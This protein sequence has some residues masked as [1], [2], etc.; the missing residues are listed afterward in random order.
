MADALQ[1]QDIEREWSKH[2]IDQNRRGAR[3]TFIIVLFLYPAFG[4]LDY[5]YAPPDQLATLWGSRVVVTAVTL[6]MLFAGLNSKWFERWPMPITGAYI[7]MCGWAISLMVSIMGG[8]ASTY[9]AGLI[10]VMIGAGLLNLWSRNV[11]ITVHGGIVLSYFLPNLLAGRIGDKFTAISNFFF[12]TGS[13]IIVAAGQIFTYRSQYQQLVTQLALQRTKAHLEEAHD[14]LKQL[15]QFKSKFFANITHELKTPLTMILSPLELTIQGE[16]GPVTDV[17]KATLGSMLRSGMKLLKLINDLLDLTK[18]EESRIR[19]RIGQHDLVE[20]MRSLVAQVQPLAQRKS[21]DMTFE[22]DV[23]RSVAWCDIERVERVF[24]NLLSNAAK[25]TPQ[26]GHIWVH[27]VDAPDKVTVTVRDDGPGFPADKAKAVFERF[28]QVEMGGTRK[29]GGTGI[30]LA[31]ARELVDLHGGRIWAQAEVGKGACFTV[32]LPKDREHFRPEAVASERPASTAQEV[33]KAE[34]E[35]NF[36]EMAVAVAGRDDYKLLDIAEATDRRVVERDP[37]ENSRAWTVLVVEDN[38]DIIRVVHLTLRRHFK[39]MAAPDGQRGLEM[40]RAQKPNLIVTDLMMP[41]MDGLEMTR[42]L[43]ADPNTKHIPIIMLTARGDIEDRVTGLDSGVNAYLSKP[44]SAKELLSTT[45]GLLNIQET[46]ADILLTQRLDSLETIAGGLAHEINNPLNY[47][48]NAV[49]RVQMDMAE[50]LRL[51]HI[52]RELTAEEAAKL[53]KLE[54]RV[55]RMFDTADSGVKRIAGTVQLMGRYSREGYTRAPRQHDVFE[56]A[57]D[58]VG[59]VL[60]AT[61]REVKVTTD[62]EGQGVIE[63]IP[64]EFNQ[65]L[66]NLVQ[67][68]IEAVTEGTGTV[69]LRGRVEDG[70][71]LL[72]VKDNGPGI[73]EDVR[74]KIFTPFFTTKGPGR[75]MGMGLTITWRVVQSIGGTIQVGGQVGV[76]TEFALKLPAMASAPRS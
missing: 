10:L 46:Q 4:I 8:L 40:A 32:E 57:R 23:Q 17:Q 34:T 67:N 62:F 19:L 64:E 68:A 5:V 6:L 59:L 60:P 7:L 3:T 56:A 42:E 35:G 37:D 65:V 2:L 49:T 50:V 31:L 61:G 26:H 70:F 66:T 74:A 48:K 47:I 22:A 53:Q 72:T 30:G 58:V 54:E 43:R 63:C 51:V 73:P 41:V 15:D 27:L 18:L 38:P 75:G 52:G 16:L 1:D 71:V 13:A 33:A 45:R 11:A 76:G 24:I 29:Y 36:N 39:V 25:F 69:E 28:Y 21:V 55:K 14:Q 9:Y 12:L 44:F 20:Y